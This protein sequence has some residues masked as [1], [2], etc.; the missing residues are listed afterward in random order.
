MKDVWCDRDRNHINDRNSS[1]ALLLFPAVLK[2]VTTTCSFQQSTRHIVDE[3]EA[4]FTFTEEPVIKTKQKETLSALPGC[5]HLF[6]N[7]YHAYL[8][9]ESQSSIQGDYFDLIPPPSRSYFVRGPKPPVAYSQPY[10]SPPVVDAR[11]LERML[12]NKQQ[13]PQ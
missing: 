1:L 10:S 7:A 12:V 4:E 11:E 3:L 2:G 13:R 6:N 9:K 8:R 5:L